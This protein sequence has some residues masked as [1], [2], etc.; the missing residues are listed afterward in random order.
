MFHAG[1]GQDTITDFTPSVDHIDLHGYDL[2]SF[3]ALQSLMIE[4]DGDTVIR[5]DPQN[6][7][8]LQSVTPD[9]SAP[10]T[11]SCSPDVTVRR[12]FAGAALVGA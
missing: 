5:F 4:L 6:T 7:L 9:S 11:S 10:A 3:A 1:D 8:T 12:F 2:A